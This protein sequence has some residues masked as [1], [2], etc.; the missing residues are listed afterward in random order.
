MS[1]RRGTQHRR[2]RP[3]RERATLATPAGFVMYVD[4]EGVES[5]VYAPELRQALRHECPICNA[6]AD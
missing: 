3:T 2:R 4:G 5:M 6:E 1:K